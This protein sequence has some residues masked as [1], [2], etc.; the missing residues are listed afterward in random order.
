[1]ESTD[2]DFAKKARFIFDK[3]YPVINGCIFEPSTVDAPINEITSQPCLVILPLP[4]EPKHKQNSNRIMLTS[5]R[6]YN[7]MLQRPRRNRIVIAPGSVITSS[8]PSIYLMPWNGFGKTIKPGEPDKTA[9]IHKDKIKPKAFPEV[10]TPIFPGEFLKVSRSQ[11]GF[12]R[13]FL[14]P[15]RSTE[16]MKSVIEV[17]LQKYPKDEDKEGNLIPKE[18]FKKLLEYLNNDDRDG[19]RKYIEELMEALFLTWWED[20]KEEVNTNFEKE[21]NYE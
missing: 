20:K 16:Q 21:K 11:A 15:K 8:E 6:R 13:E 14:N 18:L 5:Q 12:L 1:M 10:K 19:M 9:E 2:R 4:Y 3:V 17:R 7:T